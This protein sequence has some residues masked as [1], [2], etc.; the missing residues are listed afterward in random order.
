[1]KPHWWGILGLIGWSYLISALIFLFAK[2]RLWILIIAMLLLNITNIVTGDGSSPALTMAGAVIGVIYKKRRNIPVLL[3]FG[4]VMLAAGFAIRPWEGISKIRATPA[5]VLICTGISILFFTGL[6]ALVDIKKKQQWFAIIKPAGTSTLT[7]YLLPYIH[8]SIYAMIGISLPLFLRTGIP[9]II[10]SLIYA[11]IIILIT[12][13]L[14]K[15][16][17]RLKI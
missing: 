15:K 3:L 16:Q 6:I 4:I 8:Y 7:A 1:M 13:W 11:L 9:G 14:E 2:G 5:W 12:G 10:K 17:L